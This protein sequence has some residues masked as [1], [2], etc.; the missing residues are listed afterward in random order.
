MPSDSTSVGGGS[1]GYSSDSS[2]GS[3]GSK[4]V[5]YE[6]LRLIVK[7]FA[8]LPVR[9]VAAYRLRPSSSNETYKNV[10]EFASYV[11][12]KVL[13]LRVRT[14]FGTK[15]ECRYNLLCLGIP[16]N[17]IPN[18]LYDGGGGATKRQKKRRNLQLPPP[19]VNQS[20]VAIIE[21]MDED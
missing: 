15:L 10:M 1:G 6:N 5:D 13:R 8:I 20:E 3:S 9:V 18:E 17:V 7:S 2:G 14:I 11:M 16:P 12:G 4:S 21:D 19:A